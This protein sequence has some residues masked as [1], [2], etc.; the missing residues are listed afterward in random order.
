MIRTCHKKVHFFF[1]LKVSMEKP[2]SLPMISIGDSMKS[3]RKLKSTIRVQCQFGEVFQMIW[4]LLS[5]GKLMV[6]PILRKEL[7]IS[8][9][10]ILK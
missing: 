9:L 4:T 8:N 10:K 7:I 5:H 6:S 2:I 1:I 3:K